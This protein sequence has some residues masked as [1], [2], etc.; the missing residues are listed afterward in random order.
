MFPYELTEDQQKSVAQIEVDMESPQYGPPAL[1]RRGLRQDRG[2]RAWAF[3]A[4]VEGEQAI[5]AP[6]TTPGAAAQHHQKSASAG[7]P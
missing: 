2:S 7:F 6:T 5:L 4:V 1:R 3:K